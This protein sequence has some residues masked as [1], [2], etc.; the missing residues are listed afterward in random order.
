MLAFCEFY[1]KRQ[2]LSLPS[3]PDLDRNLIKPKDEDYVMADDF[4]LGTPATIGL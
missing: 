2:K 4:V 3:Y 1:T